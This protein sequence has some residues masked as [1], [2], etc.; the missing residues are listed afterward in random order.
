MT[1]EIYIDDLAEPVLTEM[2]RG[3]R[4]FGETLAV[5]LN[6]E[7]ILA[8]AEQNTGLSDWGPD[9]FLQRGKI[10]HTPGVQLDGEHLLSRRVLNP[11]YALQIDVPLVDGLDPVNVVAPARVEAVVQLDQRCQVQFGSGTACRHKRRREVQINRRV[12]R[13]GDIDSRP[14]CSPDSRAIA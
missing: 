11:R 7:S 12:R 13:C 1:D 8:E 2:Q 5:E 3:A 4:E 14:I 6:R 9:D 10:D